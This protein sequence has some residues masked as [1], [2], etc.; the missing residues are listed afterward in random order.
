MPK[1]YLGEAFGLLGKT[2]PIL[3]VRLGSY[4]ALGAALGRRLAFDLGLIAP[5]LPPFPMPG[6]FRSEMEYLRALTFDAAR[7]F[8]RPSRDLLHSPLEMADMDAAVERLSRAISQGERVLIYG[9]YD[10]DGTTATALLVSFLRLRTDVSYFIPDRYQDGYG[11]N[12]RGIDHAAD[13]GASLIIAVDCGIT[14]IDEARYARERG[15]D[16]IICDHHT[17]TPA[18]PDC[19]AV[20]DPKRSDCGYPFKEL[21]G[22]GIAF[23]LVVA[24]LNALGEDVEE[25][26]EYLDL[27]ALSTASDIVPMTGENRILMA[28]GLACL[29]RGARP[30][31]RQL[32]ELAGVDL[33]T[34]STSR[35]V[36]GIGPRINAAGRL[37][38]ASLAV[39]LLLAEQSDEA[40]AL[41]RQLEELNQQRRTLDAKT[42]GEAVKLADRQITS[43]TPHALVLH[44]AEWHLG[45]IGIVASRIVERYL[46]E[47]Y[48]R[49]DVTIAISP[50]MRTR[51]L[52]MGVRQALYVPLGVDVDTFSPA[53]RSDERRA[54]LGATA[55][56][57]V[58]VYAGRLD[59]EKRPD[60]VFDAFERLPDRLSARL[61]I[62]GDGPMR[63]R[64]EERAASNPR[65][66]VAPFVQDRAELATLL[67]SCDVYA[68]AMAHETFGLSV[69][70]AQACGL[71]VVGVH[72]GAMVDRVVDGVDGFLVE[73]G[74]PDAMAQRIAA[75]PRDDWQR[76]G[77]HAR[78]R[79]AAEFSWRRTF[80][81]LAQI[82]RSR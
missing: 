21:S 74:S 18:L 15:I 31:I 71:P 60:I 7:S 62:A 53:R 26:Y 11:L 65:V 56:D 57:V 16:L 50:A 82:Y 66:R 2:M 13:I 52:A 78:D 29:G 64:L 32:A 19:T 75:T 49:C 28:E 34:C 5:Q 61:V 58:M 59:A 39:D 12:V 30:G 77:Q 44:D 38:H 14:A 42:A 22:C 67:A 45:V 55:N 24:V 36:F 76:M 3:W 1:I 20:I 79:V 35:I 46:R 37:G 81:T 43:G 17:P 8:F 68:S 70:E 25:A 40:A 54:E 73:P 27:V 72:A 51:L 63:G 69:V 80:E 23:K 41:A 48:T 6:H 47:L 4:L 9:D 10:V 33:A